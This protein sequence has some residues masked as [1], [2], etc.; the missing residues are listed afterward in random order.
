MNES[1]SIAS[2]AASSLSRVF[3]ELGFNVGRLKTGTPPRIDGK[4]VDFAKCVEQKS[5]AFPCPFSILHGDIG[6]WVPPLDQ[7]SCFGTRTTKD[8]EAW[9]RE[10][11]ASGRGATFEVDSEGERVAKEPRYCP[12]LETKYKR[13]PNRTHHIWLE[14]EGLDTDVIYPNG[15]SCSL[16][17]ED[18]KHLLKTIPGLEEAKL[19]VPAYSVEYDFIDPKSLDNTLQTKIVKGLYL[20]GQI[21]GTTGYEEAAAQGLLAGA[22][23]AVPEDPL[24]VSRSDSYLGVLVD[25]LIM[26]GTAEPYRMM[27]SRA[28]FRLLLRPDNADRRLGEKAMQLG[29]VPEELQQA[30]SYRRQVSITLENLL[31]EM[32]LSSTAWNRNG[33]KTAQDGSMSSAADMLARP[34]VSLQTLYQIARTEF[35]DNKDFLDTMKKLLEH[36]TVCS[37]MNA[38][39][40]TVH[41]CYY[42][43]YLKRQQSM[44]AELQREESITI[45]DDVDYNQ[46]QISTE[47]RE[48]LSAFR[49]S[50]LLQAQRIPGVTPAGLMM[51]LQFIRNK[52][53][54]QQR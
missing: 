18:Q 13:F 38:V 23:A 12:S 26:R 37:P 22:N 15:L 50:N 33:I 41:D 28:E 25:D 35:S 6:N 19:L 47:D 34:D 3:Y 52:Q 14:P 30:M 10:C 27:T 20:A 40:S 42:R 49:P 36:E 43:P 24:L 46:I 53:R 21:N 5:D 51:L 11:M 44:A 29:L 48:K 16:E 4:T 1:D 45:P 54:K 8:T 17:I 7:V 2:K 32:S 9:M 39:S 31:Y